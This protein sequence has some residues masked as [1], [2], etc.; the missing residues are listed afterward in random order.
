MYRNKKSNYK[1][2]ISSSDIIIFCSDYDDNDNPFSHIRYD[3]NGQ[4]L[5]FSG[6]LYNE[7]SDTLAE[8]YL[9]IKCSLPHPKYR[10]VNKNPEGG[11]DAE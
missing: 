10:K 2:F 11:R 6:C 4:P 3:R 5:E 7:R 9:D 1:T 8:I